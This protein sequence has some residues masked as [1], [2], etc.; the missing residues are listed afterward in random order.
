MREKRELASWLYLFRPRL[1]V[2]NELAI[3]Q[4][5][6][7]WFPRIFMVGEENAA[8]LA[9]CVMAVDLNGTSQ[10]VMYINAQS[11][12]RYSV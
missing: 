6:S 8:E 9:V 11:R 7:E 10:S 4:S 2:D 5:I 1:D 12:T 3:D